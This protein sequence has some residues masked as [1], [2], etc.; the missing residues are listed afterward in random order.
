RR[1]HTRSK[2]DWSSDVCS[3]DLYTLEETA[4]IAVDLAKNNDIKDDYNDGDYDVDRS[5]MKD[6]QTAIK[7]FYS[8]GTLASEAAVLMTDAL[9]EGHIGDVEGYVL[10]TG[11]HEVLDLGDDEYTQ[12]KPHPMI[13]PATRS[14]FIAKAAQDKETAVIL[15]DIVLG[16]GSHD[17]M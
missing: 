7:G 17:D 6:S 10:K 5:G 9:G 11:A 16:Y 4:R 15:L 1:R 3:S 13:D 12:G 8:G 2:R 14:E